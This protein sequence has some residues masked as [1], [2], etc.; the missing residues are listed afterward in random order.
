[1]RPALLSLMLGQYLVK[2]CLAALDTPFFY[3]LTARP[4][5]PRG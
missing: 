2:L 5:P 4:R 3:L 1:M